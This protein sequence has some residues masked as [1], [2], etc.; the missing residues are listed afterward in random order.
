MAENL[1]SNPV[2]NW[3][4]TPEI[5]PTAGEGAPGY[6][7]CNTDSV[8]PTTAVTQW[9]TYRLARFPT[10]AKIKRVWTYL[11][12]IDTNGTATATLDFNI[13]FS[14]DTNDGTPSSL[15]GTIPSNKRDG[16][17]LAFVASTGYST[18]YANSGT[19]NKLFGNVAITAAGGATQSTDITYKNVTAAQGFFPVNRDDDIW[20]I[21]GFVTATGQ[22]QDPG[23]K[24]DIFVVV[25]AAVATAAVGVIGIEIDY[26]V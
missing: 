24:M 17:S 19:G 5:A 7:I 4:A 6:R 21:Y 14:D 11:S 26:V 8:N 2:T 13:A 15:Q 12:G 16:T 23:G 1:K 18:A 25:A 10:N 9:S 20:N 3:D 22:A